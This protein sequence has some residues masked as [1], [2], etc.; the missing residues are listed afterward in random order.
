MLIHIVPKLF[1][2]P[3]TAQQV[4]AANNRRLRGLAEIVQSEIKD[5]GAPAALVVPSRK[6]D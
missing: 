1:A 2:D 5:S 3:G 4:I 6:R